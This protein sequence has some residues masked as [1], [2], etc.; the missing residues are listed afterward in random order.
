MS[1]DKEPQFLICKKWNIDS[2]K[3]SKILVYPNND[4]TKTIYRYVISH[5]SLT[6]IITN[7]IKIE[8]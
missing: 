6:I 3:H 4:P 1:R 2:V 8:L 5:P 7:I